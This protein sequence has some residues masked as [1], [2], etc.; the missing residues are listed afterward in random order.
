MKHNNVEIERKY[1]SYAEMYEDS[2]PDKIYYKTSVS[3]DRYY[4][5]P[6]GLLRLRDDQEKGIELTAKTY[7]NNNLHRR[8]INLPMI[9]TIDIKDCLEFAEVAGWTL[10]LE[11]KQELQIWI[12]PTV[13]VSQTII[14][15]LDGKPYRF[16]KELNCITDHYAFRKAQFVEI[17]ALDSADEKFAISE[18]RRYQKILNLKSSDIIKYSLVQLFGAFPLKG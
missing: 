1:L 18:I 17:E 3:H 14:T 10:R 4:V 16:S 2:V 7:K 15:D 11:F 6:N 5:T 8:E 12:C 9:A 13:V